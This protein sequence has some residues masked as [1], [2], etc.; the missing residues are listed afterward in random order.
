MT[1]K[2]LLSIVLIVGFSSAMIAQ[3]PEI[4]QFLEQQ[5]EYSDI[6]DLLDMLA[7]LEQS[8][9]DLNKATAQQLAVLPWISDVMASAIIQY[10]DQVGSF[11]SIEDLA[12]V[13]NFDPDLVLIL[14][15]YL[16]VSSPKTGK[17][18][19][20]SV[21]TRLSRKI[22]YPQ[23]SEDSLCYS[24][25]TK[26][27]NRL[28]L[29]YGNN[30][31]IGL[32]LEKDSGER[33]IDDLRLY[34]LS[35]RNQSNENRLILGSYRLEFAQGL[36]F[37]SP[38]G[39]YKGNDPIFPAKRRGRE[40][41]AYTMVDENASLYG[42]AGQFCFKIY[43]F[44][45]FLS[46]TQRDA[47][48][49][50]SGI[51]KNF[52][53]SGY[54]RN[55][56]EMDKKDRLNEQLVGSRILIKP[57]SNFSLGTTYYRSFFNPFVA[58]QN[59]NLHRFAFNGKINDLAG[60]DY[61]LTVGQFNLFG[62][63]ARSKNK[64]FALFTGLLGEFDRMGLIIVGRKYSKDFTS[65]YGHSF[66]E[67]SN[68]PQ[69]EQGI[70]FGFRY[71]PIKN[72]KLNIYFDQFKFPW[73]TFYVPMPS[74]G[75]ELL[76]RAEHK[77]IKNLLLSLQ[78]KLEQ[79]D[80]NKREIDRVIPRDKKNMRIQI[81]YRP[82]SNLKLRLRLEKNRVSYHYYRQLQSRYPLSHQGILLYQDMILK[83]HPSFEVAARLTFFDTDHYESRL[84][85]FE[86]DVPG[87]LTNLMLYGKGTR[88]YVRMRWNIKNI[89]NLSLKLG[90]TQYHSRPSNESV[91]A[92]KPEKTI[93]T[94]NLQLET[95]W[96]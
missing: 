94:I 8:P 49:N 26:L 68:N 51:V 23:S 77:I 70:Y 9:L 11:K 28:N 32:L 55:A 3:Q 36:I 12:Q 81:D 39:Y 75:K 29:N 1:G 24:S 69:N 15:N 59:E 71:K 40:L 85:Q 57:A 54:H 60:I 62:E 73:R 86:H 95:T 25:P 90:S 27:Y 37:G 91:S 5:K 44:F 67:N 80:Q 14:R 52:Y 61:N 20:L 63:L 42:V 43:Q 96:Y 72:L 65:F 92:L 4:E 6:S 66:G 2:L 31:R 35:Y 33:Q 87:M 30:F 53:T 17:N 21:K 88:A 22:E 18:L 64:G 50:D 89:I 47:T 16:T 7:E 78:F 76:L 84:Y 48:L 79:K 56:N 34:Y 58:I 41:L 93:N 45:L 74:Q 83:F 82:L 13:E 38:Y 46:A 10:R 19:S